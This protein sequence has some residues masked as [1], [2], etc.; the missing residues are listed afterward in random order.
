[1]VL[2]PWE[3][4][5]VLVEKIQS[6]PSNIFFVILRFE[7][8]C[9][10]SLEQLYFFLLAKHYQNNQL[11]EQLVE[12]NDCFKIVEIMKPYKN[13][14]M[15]SEIRERI[16]RFA[17]LQKFIQCLLFREDLMINKNKRLVYKQPTFNSEE[18]AFWG[19]S[20]PSKLVSVLKP[21]SLAG[22]NI[23]G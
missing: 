8:Y 13:V 15:D 6:S 20:T 10:Y 19:V 4:D 18:T 11:C 1:M 3:E 22:N 16:M 2:Y 5:V 17:V 14:Y 23:M 9:F 21:S 7:N 12:E